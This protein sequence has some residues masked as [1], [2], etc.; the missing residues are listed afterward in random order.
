MLSQSASFRRVSA[1]VAGLAAKFALTVMSSLADNSCNVSADVVMS[2]AAS[3][4]ATE[5]IP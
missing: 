3:V 2:A 5:T 4:C 1:G